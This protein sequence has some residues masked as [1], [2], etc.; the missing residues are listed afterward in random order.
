MLDI[1]LFRNDINLLA[2]KL[3]KKGYI[4]DIEQFNKIENERKSLQNQQQDLQAKRNKLSKEVGELKRNK[5][6]ADELLKDLNVISNDL[7]KV[8]ESFNAIYDQQ[9]KLLSEIPNVPSDDTP[10]GASEDD[11]KEIKV[12][13][14]TK[15]LN[16]SCLDHVSIG[17]QLKL[18]LSEAASKIAQSRFIVLKGKLARIHRALAQMMI[19]MHTERHGYTE[20]YVPQLVNLKSM[21]GTG[22]LPKF[23]D[24]QFILSEDR[25]ALIP[26]AEVP[27]TNLVAGEILSVS[28]LPIKMVAHSACY[29]REAGSYGKDT[30]GMIRQHQ[31]DKVEMVQIVD[32]ENG[33][34][35]LNDMVLHAEAVLSSLELPYRVV[36]LC[37]GD[38][39]FSAY[40]TYDLEV[41][42]PSQNTYREISSCSLCTD[43]QARRIQARFKNEQGEINL[44]H[45]L[46]GSGVAVGRALIDILENH[47]DGI[48]I[49]IP[50]ALRPYLGGQDAL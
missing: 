34:K 42:L 17:E 25:L 29:R 3:A 15:S 6:N 37:T 24:D 41:W 33:P 5:Q 44:V 8:T 36:E 12:I 23:A 22:Q 10:I 16:Q 7:K 49:H 21:Y 2:H 4:L 13:G 38:L 11:N 48:K 45:T 1:Q 46:N 18:Y 47:F 28:E 50:K 20:Y 26:T 9:K 19:D 40:R 43:F 39:G 31:F 32:P 27:L 30:R 14:D 35:A